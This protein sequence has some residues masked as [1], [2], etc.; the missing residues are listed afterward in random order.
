MSFIV[1]FH[2]VLIKD[3]Y[4]QNYNYPALSDTVQQSK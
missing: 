4:N 2:I 3:D 1:M